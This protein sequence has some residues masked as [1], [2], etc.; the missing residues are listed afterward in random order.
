MLKLELE[1]S[2]IDYEALAERLLPLLGDKLRQNGGA[3][4]LLGGASS[5]MAKAA[6]SAL[7]QERKD[8]MAADLINGSAAAIAE[9]IQRAAA[10]NGVS[11]RISGLHAE[12][13]G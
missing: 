7:P 6:L 13:E 3:G 5:A 12:T 10:Q 11:C 2:D 1:L 9:A 8:R 4:A